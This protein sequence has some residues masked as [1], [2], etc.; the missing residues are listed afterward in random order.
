MER[1]SLGQKPQM[2]K[3]RQATVTYCGQLSRAWNIMH[4]IKLHHSDRDG[5]DNGITIAW[6]SGAKAKASNRDIFPQ[7]SNDSK[8]YTELKYNVLT[9]MYRA[10]QSQSLGQKP[11]VGT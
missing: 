9:P 3:L 11:E 7:L 1:Q 10:M 2:G 8:R 4:G 6:S 5:Q